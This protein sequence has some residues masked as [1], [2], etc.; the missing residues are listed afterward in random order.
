MREIVAR[1]EAKGSSRIDQRER[2]RVE[3]AERE[4]LARPGI[5]LEEVEDI[6]SLPEFDAK[7]ATK[8]RPLAPS[9]CH[10]RSSVSSVT[11]YR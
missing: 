10:N 6:I 9:S 1:R 8:Q 3:S 5:V 2:V 4:V 7:T 11:T